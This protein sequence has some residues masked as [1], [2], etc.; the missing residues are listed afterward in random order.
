VITQ[1]QR[2]GRSSRHPAEPCRVSGD[3]ALLDRLRDRRGAR[4]DSCL[5][6][7]QF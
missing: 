6:N 5:Q 7:S 3:D 1:H 2:G 4:H